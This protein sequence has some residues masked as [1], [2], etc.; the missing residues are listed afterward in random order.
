[1]AYNIEVAKNLFNT[2]KCLKI[3]GSPGTVVG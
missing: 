2:G 3:I 1:M